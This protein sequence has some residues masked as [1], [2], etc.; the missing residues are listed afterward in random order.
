M[1]AILEIVLPVFSLILLGWS[2]ARFQYLSPGAGHV[3]AQFAFKVAM[4]ALLF[5]TTLN[6]APWNAD[7]VLLAVA[8]F[9]AMLVIWTIASLA[10]RF[11]LGRPAE[12]TAAIAMGVCF[13]NT[14]M[15]GIPVA[16]TAFGEAAAVPVA[17]IITIDSPLLWL[18]ATLQ[19]ELFRRREG[20]L[21]LDTIAGVARDV[22]FNPIV[23]PLILGTVGRQFGLALPPIADKLLA[24]LAQAAV[25]TA[26]VAL[27][28]TLVSF[29]IKGQRPTIGLILVLKLL[30]FPGLVVLATTALQLPPV[31]IAVATLLAA[32]P[33]GANAFLFASRY[34]RGVGSVSAAV[35]VSTGLAVLSVSVVLFLLRGGAG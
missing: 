8:Y 16:L 32:M 23:L 33:V 19:M 29:E 3:L 28:T 12:D 1:A 2:A 9:G 10:T 6:L 4:P 17:L 34:E 13:G 27:G 30:A 21:R 26:L 14:V 25:P 5:R 18:L 15:L 7:P 35:A 22:V 24:L 20:G 31:W 11:V